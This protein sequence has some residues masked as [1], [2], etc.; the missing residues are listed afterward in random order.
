M[1]RINCALP[2]ETVYRPFSITSIVA[3]VQ[4]GLEPEALHVRSDSAPHQYVRL[5]WVPVCLTS[6]GY[7]EALMRQTQASSTQQV[8]DKRQLI[9]FLQHSCTLPGNSLGAFKFLYE[10][11]HI[12][13]QKNGLNTIPETHKT[14]ETTHI[15]GG[16]PYGWP[17]KLAPNVFLQREP[18]SSMIPFTFSSK[19]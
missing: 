16:K 19:T 11:G 1:D 6:Q 4:S 9:L 18:C 7:C 8:L 14:N 10:L 2:T 15:F 12:M 3:A 13:T 17:G 5:P